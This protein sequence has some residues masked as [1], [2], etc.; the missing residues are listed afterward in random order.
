MSKET[1]KWR[2]SQAIHHTRSNNAIL[3]SFRSAE[4]REKSKTRDAMIFC[5]IKLNSA[6][7]Q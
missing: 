1:Q 3:Q 7:L 2:K 5:T 6:Q 4:T